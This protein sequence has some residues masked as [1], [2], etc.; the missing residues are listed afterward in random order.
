[1]ELEV[2]I[3]RTDNSRNDLSVTGES[4][5]GFV[6][7]DFVVMRYGHDRT[8]FNF[9]GSTRAVERLTHKVGECTKSRVVDV[10]SVDAPTIRL[11]FTENMA[12]G[13]EVEHLAAAVDGIGIGDDGHD[14]SFR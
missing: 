1:M 8:S 2:G 10:F 9:D 5:L 11:E 4:I 3:G 14:S 6:V 12:D 7:D 13:V